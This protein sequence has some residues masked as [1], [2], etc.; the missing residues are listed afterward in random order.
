MS[1]TEEKALIEC[2]E[3]DRA[4]AAA[5]AKYERAIVAA[6]A[7]YKRVKAAASAELDRSCDAAWAQNKRAQEISAQEASN[8]PPL[9]AFKLEASDEPVMTIHDDAG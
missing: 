1:D 5:L 2:A 4:I 8:P 7:E 6:R 3:Y 9:I